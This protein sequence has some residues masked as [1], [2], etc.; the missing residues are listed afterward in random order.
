MQPKESFCG[1]SFVRILGSYPILDQGQLQG[2]QGCVHPQTVV[3]GEGQDGEAAQAQLETQIYLPESSKMRALIYLAG[4][5]GL[6][7]RSP[8]LSTQQ[9][10]VTEASSTAEFS[11]E[12]NEM[13]CVEIYLYIKGYS[14]KDSRSKEIMCCY[15]YCMGGGPSCG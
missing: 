8:D 7:V 12:S 11:A 10:S 14:Q 6:H 15:A 4:T 5:S 1:S 9:T 3:T 13:N 2:D